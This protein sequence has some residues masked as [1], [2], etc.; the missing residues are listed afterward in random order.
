MYKITINKTILIFTICLTSIF[1]TVSHAE[2]INS[3]KLQQMQQFV[4]LMHGF[5]GII[6][7]TYDISS[8]AEKSAIFQM[9][10]IKEAYEES[11]QDKKIVTAFEEILQS[12]DNPTIRNA[13]YFMLG[14]ALKETGQHDKAIELLKEGLNENI[15]LAN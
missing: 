8:D 2:D 11:G 13:A 14:D 7:A 12:T 10:K 9:H 15:K 3:A 4:D 5:F 1:S 6:D